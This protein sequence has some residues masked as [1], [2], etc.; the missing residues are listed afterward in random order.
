[1]IK[2]QTGDIQT[3]PSVTQKTAQDIGIRLHQ[4]LGSEIGIPA[5]FCLLE[6]AETMPRAKWKPPYVHFNLIKN[7]FSLHMSRCSTEFRPFADL[8]SVH[9]TAG[10]PSIQSRPVRTNSRASTILP[11]FV[12]YKFEIHNGMDYVNLVVAPDM[13]GHKFGEFAMT[14]K[15]PRFPSVDELKA[16]REEASKSK[17]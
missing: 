15:F 7:I 16:K 8:L 5:S 11:Q 3:D 17:F 10:G 14:R 12:G 6:L 2:V 9:L 13:V 4:G 1:M